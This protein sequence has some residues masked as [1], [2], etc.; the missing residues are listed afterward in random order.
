M[1]IGVQC[2][3]CGGKFLAPDEQAGAKVK[4]PDCAAAIDVGYPPHHQ[5]TSP[6]I[7]ATQSVS[8]AASEPVLSKN[9]CPHC[10]TTNVAK[11]RS[12]WIAY[13]CDYV[14][15][16][17][18]T[19]WRPACPK[20]AAIAAIIAG[21]FL[22]VLFLPIAILGLFNPP[23]KSDILGLIVG[24]VVFG[25]L[26]TLG[27]GFVAYGV[28]VL[29]GKSGKFAILKLVQGK[30]APIPQSRTPTSV[31]SWLD[32]LGQERVAAGQHPA[33]ADVEDDVSVRSFSASCPSAPSKA[34]RTFGISALSGSFLRSLKGPGQGE[35]FPQKMY[36][37]CRV[38]HNLA[39]GSIAWVPLALLAPGI[40]IQMALGNSQTILVAV[41]FCILGYVIVLATKGDQVLIRRE[42]IRNVGFDGQTFAMSFSVSPVKGL[43]RMKFCVA[44]LHTSEFVSDFHEAFP[45]L[46]SP[47]ASA[48]GTG[49]LAAPTAASIAPPL[50][51]LALWSF[52]LG[53]F[54]V[55]WMSVIAGVPALV[56]GLL[57]LSRIS[58]SAGTLS[59][60]RHAIAGVILGSI[61]I[62]IFVVM[63]LLTN[64]A[65]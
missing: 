14:C 59:G 54:A 20:W 52:I 62:V 39:I 23:P 44:P 53:L 34:H 29:R 36:V 48:L 22:G 27:V 41:P 42:N 26:G 21:G 57:A 40:F 8:P 11:M 33:P 30:G 7:A 18:G 37:R 10:R 6:V 49:S 5:R 3:G 63:I 13:S 24:L 43:K 1:P 46:L 17:C 58:K 16:S 45:N 56:C 61:G 28:A 38:G 64:L 60:K 12:K 47:P 25:S 65:H 9:Q 4:C 55:P 50:S 19:M 2:S 15:N 35:F 51:G 32:G 31:V